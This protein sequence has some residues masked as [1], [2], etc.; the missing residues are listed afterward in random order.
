[1]N[2]IEKIKEQVA[3]FK[4]K[5][6]ALIAE[7]DKDFGVIFIPLFE[8]YPDIES[9]SWTQFSPYFN[10]GEECTFS[11]HNDFIDIDGTVDSTLAEEEF[12]DLLKSIPDDFY[13]DLF[14]N[15]VRVILLKNGKT[16]V[17]EYNHD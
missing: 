7:L 16:I 3:E 8:K 12:S 9:I 17:E 5:R 11:V 14:G 4:E 1:M 10:D 2:V 6:A 13:E 15:H